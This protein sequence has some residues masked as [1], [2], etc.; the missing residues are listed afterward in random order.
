MAF[1]AWS[2]VV[3][4]FNVSFQIRTNFNANTVIQLFYSVAGDSNK[5]FSEQ[6]S[7]YCKKYTPA[8]V[9]TSYRCDIQLPRHKKIAK[10]RVDLG[11]TAGLISLRK[12]KL[13]DESLSA[14]L[15][16]QNNITYSHHLKYVSGNLD[17][18]RDIT[19]EST[20][21]DPYFFFKQ[22][23]NQK[24]HSRISFSNLFSLIIMFFITWLISAQVCKTVINKKRE[25]RVNEPVVVHYKTRKFMNVEVLRFMLVMYVVLTHFATLFCKLGGKYELFYNFLDYGRSQLFFVIAGFFLFF[26]PRQL[27]NS[28]AFF[29]IKR[30]LRL[31]GL[32]IFNTIL[33]YV[34]LH[35]DFVRA[36]L[37]FNLLNAT[38]INFINNNDNNVVGVAWYVNSLFFLSV[39]YFAIY[40]TL[41]ENY[42]LLFTI[43]ITAVSA[44]LYARGISLGNSVQWARLPGAVFSLSVGILLCRSYKAISNSEF[45]CAKPDLKTKF[46]ISSIEILC[47]IL[48]FIGLY[49]KTLGLSLGNNI[50]S[51]FIAVLFWL[52]L[53]N[54]GWLSQSLNKSWAI[55]FGRYTY[56]IFLTHSTV[57]FC[58]LQWIIPYYNDWLKANFLLFITSYFFVVFAFSIFCHYFVEIPLSRWTAK[59]FLLKSFN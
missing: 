22:E 41:P 46:F 27:E 42:A 20:G 29:T 13:M 19:L 34:V 17:D 59:K 1:T 11:V 18:S 47:F 44:N 45:I 57:N 23:L 49:C 28:I 54:K 26:S 21:N 9:W 51:A 16:N 56:S 10:L 40:K 37:E 38:L 15:A 25:K 6:K 4:K 2:P 50:L 5:E 3:S 36:P 32:V 53:C 35:F 48:L 30:W 39:L 33:C 52:F 31:A 58:L 12:F 8:N 7:A 43:L 14:N 55:Y 24:G